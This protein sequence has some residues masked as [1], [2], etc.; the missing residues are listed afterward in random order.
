MKTHLFKSLMFALVFFASSAGYSAGLSFTEKPIQNVGWSATYLGSTYDPASNATTFSYRMTALSWEKDLSHWVLALDDAPIASSGCTNV[1][2]GLDPT[3]GV[4]GWKCDDGLAAGSTRVYSVVF[5][6]HLG[7]EPTSYS[8]KGGTYFAVGPTTG[9]GAPILEVVKYSIAG[10]VFLDANRNGVIDADEPR[11]A[12]TSVRL[13]GPDATQFASTDSEGKFSFTGLTAGNRTLAVDF[14]TPAISGDANETIGQY[15]TATLPVSQP[16]TVGPS[17]ENR[18]F[19]FA[20]GFAAVVNDFDPLDPD[21]D[22]FTFSGTG[23]TIGFWKHQI[24]SA[25]AG[26]TKG[27]QIGA[28]ELQGYLY[29]GSSSVRTLFSDVFGDIPASVPGAYDYALAVLSSTASD[30]ISLL[31]KQLLATE[32][33]HLS[34]RGINNPW[35]QSALIAWSEYLVKNAGLFTRTELL[36]AKDI[37]DLINNSGE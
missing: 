22:G 9:P 6:G 18:N 2:F 15:F 29:G 16:V 14:A 19:G 8:V 23:K 31:K 13:T 17:Q 5:S 3:T 21:R 30:E 7:E 4:H 33:N 11:L 26:K 12:N 32:L 20:P 28:T 1:K 24:A 10:V 27:I 37:C 36:D 35:L 34:A 25:K